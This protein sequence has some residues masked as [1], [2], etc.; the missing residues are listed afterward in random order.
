MKISNS[1][2]GFAVIVILLLA[3][4][5]FAVFKALGIQE[6]IILSEQHRL[7]SFRL[8]IELF[9]SSEDLTRMARSYVSTADPTYERRYFE[10]LDIRNGARPRPANYNATYWHLAGAGRGG[11][12][13]PG[14]TIA[15]QE[16]M[17]REG[18]SE[19][20]FSLLRESQA[21]SD[22]L[23]H[24]EKQAFAAMKGLY[25]DGRGR[26]TVRRAPDRKYAVNL[27]FSE[28]YSNEKARIMLPIQYFMDEI[29]KRTKTHLNDL[30][31]ELFRI[32]VAVLALVLITLLVVLI[33][34]FRTFRHIL[35]PTKRLLGKIN[36]IASGNYAARCPVSSSNEI[37][38]LSSKF[39]YM[40]DALQTDVLRREE[41][42]KNL[43]ESEAQVRLL[44]NSTA[45]AIYGI[46]LQGNCTF[47]NQACIRMLG[48]ADIQQLLG[49]N[50]HNLIHHSYPDGRTMPNETCRIYSAFRQGKGVHVDDEVL[51]K[52]DGDS[53]PAEYQSFPQI[54]DGR[55]IGAVVTFTDITERKRVEKYREMGNEVLNV[56]NNPDF[57]QDVMQGVVDVLKSR[58]GFDAVGIRL[59]KGDDFPYFAQSGFSD[60]FLQTENSLVNRDAVGGLC[61]DQN[62]RI[63]LE[64]NCGLVLSDRTQPDCP[65]FTRFGSF[66]TN[67]SS[68]LADLPSD[69][70]PRVSPRNQCLRQGYASLAL[71]PIREKGSIIGL[72]QF[73]D[74]KKNCFSIAE[75]EQMENV[76]A[77]IGEALLRREA[78]EQI[79]HMAT[80]DGLTDLP[81][82]RLATDRLSMSILRARRNK[83]QTAVMFVDLDGFKT[84]NDTLGHE[85]G[86]YVLKEIAGRFLSCVRESDTVARV[87]GDEFLVIAGGIHAPENASRIA[88]NILRSVPRP[89]LFNGSPAVVGASIGIALYPDN[90]DDM[91]QLIRASDQAMYR[92][93]KGGKNGFC[94][95]DAT[96]K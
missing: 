44:L 78:E 31:S 18:F 20:E 23:V 71:V 33:H 22:H 46:D 94:F 6:N 32:I 68:P 39:N 28:Q 96:A 66:W 3:L 35:S 69:Q 67:D 5:G 75:I 8:A 73:A 65:C 60:S 53:F 76:A 48:Y 90:G 62:G 19:K 95:A 1:S 91:E 88:E 79:R 26:F 47:A 49:K 25:D 86:D 61:R 37:G 40:A 84:V 59:R 45:E 15:L 36:E 89:V 13:A 42:E 83:T 74:R 27:L 9:Q 57:Q 80:H 50:M 12:V 24:M 70:D 56:L 2:K 17:R 58:T 85:A 87:G 54:E 77:N 64:C 72:I 7:R 29:N 38:E 4:I 41:M 14:E 92:V 43:K 63:L 34:T 93:K 51:W 21:N 10:I 81:T 82:M 11:A 52:A 55:V 16:L 30:Q